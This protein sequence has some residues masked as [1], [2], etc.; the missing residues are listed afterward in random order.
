MELEGVGLVA[1]VPDGEEV[2]SHA[3]EATPATH[4]LRVKEFRGS[5]YVEAHLIVE[6]E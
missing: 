6:L 4:S 2:A 1:R 5:E 3:P